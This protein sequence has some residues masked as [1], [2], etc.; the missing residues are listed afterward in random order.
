M[1][2]AR[3]RRWT[4]LG[5]LAATLLVVAPTAA[6]PAAPP[7]PEESGDNAPAGEPTTPAAD[8]ID[9]AATSVKGVGASAKATPAPSTDRKAKRGGGKKR[10]AA[11]PKPRQPGSTPGDPDQSVRDILTGNHPEHS[12]APARESAELKAIRELDQELFPPVSAPAAAP[13]DTSLQL[14][15]RGA[16]VDSSGLPATS[17]AAANAKADAEEDLSWLATLNKPD[18]PVRFEPAVVRYLRFYKNEERGRRMVATW[19]RR[20]G[21]YKKAIVA[22][23]H[24]YQLPEDLLWLALVESAFD[25]TIHS[26]AGAAGLWQFMPATGR[27]YG[28]TVNRRIDERLDPERSTHAALKH[29]GDLYQRFGTWELA[30]AAYNMGYG[31]L[32]ASIRKFNTNDYWELRRLEAGLP[33]ETALYVP[34]IMAIAIATRNCKVFGC[35]QVKPDEPEPFGDVKVDKVS[36]APGVTLDD[37]AEATGAKTEV[38]AE[39]NPHVI[40]SRMPPIEQATLPRTSWTVYVPRG[41][42]AKASES[43]PQGSKPRKLATHRTR[44]GESLAAVASTYGT[45]VGFLEQLNDLVAHESPRPGTTLFVP[46][47]RTLK[48]SAAVA[49][50]LGLFAVV[51]DQDFSFADRRRVFYEPVFGDTIEDVARACGVLPSELRRWNH[52]DRRANLQEGMR[53]QIYL[54]ADAK[55]TDV[56][57]YED[58]DMAIMTAESEP[59]FDHFVGNSGRKRLEIT[60]KEGDTWTGL[61]KRYGLS[62]GMLE[63]INHKSRRSGLKVGDKVVVYA[64]AALLEQLAPEEQPPEE[65]SGAGPEQGAPDGKPGS[66]APARDDGPTRNTAERGPATSA[67]TTGASLASAALGRR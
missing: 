17:D 24:Q 3:T 64:K 58:A 57:L 8:A 47:G 31:G 4:L 65:A 19:V 12:T 11:K 10:G 46:P 40:G 62:L 38:I 29:L 53:L 15:P 37:V 5:A 9:G 22:L 45:S 43:L 32:L 52:L 44:W 33:Y 41:S 63:R 56:I 23:L 60:A 34:K 21:R 6:Q 48:S 36:V 18:F 66:S 35:D 14:P 25:S 59:F 61:G 28:L 16:Q 20:S 55:P 2:S 39:L 50:D 7:S 26:H 27:I 49:K 13:W 54:P 42:G 67:P 30:F 51:P 1:I